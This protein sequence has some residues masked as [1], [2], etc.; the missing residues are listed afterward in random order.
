MNDAQ[1][2][3]NKMGADLPIIKSAEENSFIFK[4]LKD[5]DK[6][7]AWMGLQRDIQTDS[8]FYWVDRTPLVG[9]YESWKNGEPS[10]KAGENC[11]YISTYA[12]NW[13]DTSCKIDSGVPFVCQ[14]A[15]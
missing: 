9:N 5:R 8:K 12:G 6:E 1:E 3:C 14:R 4:L 10:N 11:A 13:D 7:W 15:L 2:E